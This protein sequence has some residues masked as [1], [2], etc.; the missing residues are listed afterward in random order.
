MS[1]RLGLGKGGISMAP[2]ELV[3]QVLKVGRSLHKAHRVLNSVM[4]LGMN[5]FIRIT[6]FQGKA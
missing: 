5:A 4:K 6:R 3:E 1:A 2:S